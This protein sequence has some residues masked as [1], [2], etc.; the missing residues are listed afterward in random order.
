MKSE[1]SDKGTNLREIPLEQFIPHPAN[2]NKMSKSAFAKLVANI[3]KT[4]LYE[5]VVVRP[6]G[7]KFQLIN[8][9]HRIEALKKLEARTASAIV[10]E[11]DD[12]T[13]LTLL[14]SL[15]RLTGS[16]VPEKKSR[17][18]TELLANYSAKDIAKILPCPAAQ[19]E[20]LAAAKLPDVPAPAVVMPDAM[21]FFLSG[22]QRAIV[23]DALAKA[24]CEGQ[25]G[26][27]GQKSAAKK[28]AA[29]LALL[30]ENYIDAGKVRKVRKV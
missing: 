30:A 20:R 26:E 27:K 19:I 25:K 21:V 4:G 10:W 29:A 15:N 18:Y 7:D 13:S 11:L 9:H 6:V 22:E 24:K 2:P 23:Q 16:D 8:G 1:K 12:A 5:P 14:A 17:L 28:N 3:K